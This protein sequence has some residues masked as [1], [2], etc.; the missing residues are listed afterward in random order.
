MSVVSNHPEPHLVK[1]ILAARGISNRQLAEQLGVSETYIG[2]ILNGYVH[3]VP[4]GV[5]KRVAD[6]LGLPAEDLFHS[7][8]P[9]CGRPVTVETDLA[10]FVEAS[11]LAQGLPPRVTDPAMLAKVASIL[12]SAAKVT[13]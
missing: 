3:P 10:A 4:A 11:R 5:S 1:G 9:S 2:R 8:E 7:G 12:A 6:L 13:S